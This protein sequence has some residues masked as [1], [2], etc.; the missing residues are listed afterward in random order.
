[1]SFTNDSLVEVRL[2]KKAAHQ[3]SDELRVAA[4]AAASR[5]T[6]P[7]TREIEEELFTALF[8]SQDWKTW[9]GRK[10]RGLW[11]AMA[12]PAL[13]G[14][15]ISNT[16]ARSQKEK[17]HCLEAQDMQVLLEHRRGCK[18]GA[19]PKRATVKGGDVWPVGFEE[20]DAIRLDLLFLTTKT[21]RVARPAIIE[22]VDE[23]SRRVVKGS[24]GWIRYA[25]FVGGDPIATCYEEKSGKRTKGDRNRK[26]VT[27]KEVNAA[28]KEAAAAVG[29]GEGRFTSHGFRR[30]LATAMTMEA[31]RAEYV[32]RM[33]QWTAGSTIP[34]TT[35]DREAS[36]YQP[37][38]K[39]V[40]GALSNSSVLGL[41]PL[42]AQALGKRK[43]M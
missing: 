17:G 27:A 33:G 10:K 19:K 22:C 32:R 43:R 13:L 1:M 15:R 9:E 38:S 26:T 35:Y 3:T 7:I 25:G 4:R 36:R 34:Q 37:S 2:A 40:Q 16:V 28:I 30:K 11:L 21:T 6:L 41:I 24:A 23:D 29:C 14:S 42:D 31:G 20:D 39:L 18:K 5:D 8:S 12:I